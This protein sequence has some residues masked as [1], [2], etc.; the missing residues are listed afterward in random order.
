MMSD[1]GRENF[2]HQL[3]QIVGSIQYTN[4][5]DVHIAL[6][7][8]PSYA[9]EKAEKYFTQTKT[10][11]QVVRE[12]IDLFGFTS[13][14]PNAMDIMIE[15]GKSVLRSWGAKEPDF[16]LTNSKLTFQMTMTPEKT[17]YVTQGPD[18]QKR[19]RDGPDIASYRGLNIINTRSFS[20]EDGAPPRDVL[21]RRVRVAEYH[22]IPWEAGNHNRSYSFYDES[23]DAW[24]KFS[25]KQLWEHSA[26]NEA[27]KNQRRLVDLRVGAPAPGADHPDH[28]D[29]LVIVRPNIEHNMLGIIMGR[30]GI[31]DLGATLWGQTEL[32]VYDDSMHGIW[33]MSYKYNERAIVFNQK[34][35]IRL[36][37]IAYDGY[38]GGK[39]CTVF[40]WSSEDDKSELHERTFDLTRPYEGKSMMVMS[41]NHADKD[42][43]TWPS[44]IVFHDDIAL[45]RRDDAMHL[46]GEHAHTINKKNFRVFST[47]PYQESRPDL[48]GGAP[49]ENPNKERYNTYV[50]HMPN[51]TRFHNCKNAGMSSEE[52]ETNCN[53]LAFQGTH[54]VHEGGVM[55]SYE[56]TGNGHHGQDF[57]GVASI[58]AG[59]G[60]KMTP[61]GSLTMGHII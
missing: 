29:E 5:I 47:S 11:H 12:Y 4:D 48:G 8:A 58:R 15:E 52:N 28:H 3:Q 7:T 51:F 30:G 56:I 31:E 9:K 1:K 20:L 44:P 26:M 25:W 54:R 53:T 6:I 37:D 45:E 39:D 61:T 22:R 21:R 2:R 43:P 19:L 46:D 40:D 57:V 18:G 14:N 13:K 33:G 55:Q 49:V 38:N 24:E 60:V 35:L 42:I 34:N 27:E 50:S 17:S 41:F 10:N 23:K 16:L 59:K 32:S 36:W